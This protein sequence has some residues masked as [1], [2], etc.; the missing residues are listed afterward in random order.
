[1][2]CKSTNSQTRGFE[3]CGK[4][5]F[6]RYKFGLCSK[7]FFNWTQEDE[8]GKIYYAKS[9]QPKV[10]KVIVRANKLEA[11][12]KKESQINWRKK[13][14]TNVQLISRLIDKD[15]PCLA[16]KT[17]GQMHGG[18]VFAKGGNSTMALNLH[19]IHRQS[20]YSNTFLNDDGKL[21]EELVIEYGIDYFEFIKNIRTH[22]PLKFSNKEYQEIY[23]LSLEIS[24]MLKKKGITYELE[25]RINLRS[26]I[27]LTLG[28]Y[29]KEYCEFINN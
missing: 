26:Q 4:D 9:F 24:N 7:C 10:K 22:K 1:M 2:I 11:K 6:K 27:N 19:N 15:L 14:Q 13:L 20:A 5:I 29:E 23:F 25:E 12:E 8:R 28:I 16:R 21:R 18:H 3:S 17:M